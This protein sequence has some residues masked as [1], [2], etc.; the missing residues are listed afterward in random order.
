MR[1][2][3]RLLLVS[4]TCLLW[5]WLKGTRKL[6]LYSLEALLGLLLGRCQLTALSSSSWESSRWRKNVITPWERS[7]RSL[8]IT[9]PQGRRGARFVPHCLP[10]DHITTPLRL[11]L[12]PGAQP[13]FLLLLL[14]TL[15]LRGGGGLRTLLVRGG[16]SGPGGREE[17]A[18]QLQ[19]I[20]PPQLLPAA[21]F[22]LA[23]GRPACLLPLRM[24]VA[25]GVLLSS[26]RPVCCCPGRPICLR[27]RRLP[28]R[29]HPLH[30]GG[31]LLHQHH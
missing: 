11:L 14:R 21:G 27:L 10:A 26:G 23:S 25:F 20:P 4:V 16:C 17:A 18:R 12:L 24:S 13:I 5:P 19:S 8:A 1:H 29:W 3:Q 15:L 28:P 7:Y 30:V 9:D 2:R 6:P 31:R 22:I